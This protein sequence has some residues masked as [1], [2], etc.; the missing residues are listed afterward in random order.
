[1]TGPRSGRREIF[2][3]TMMRNPSSP[4]INQSEFV[5]E[6]PTFSRSDLRDCV[7]QIE[8]AIY[9]DRKLFVI[10]ARNS[11]LEIDILLVAYIALYR[12]SNAALR[13]E[14]W[15]HKKDVE[16]PTVRKLRRYRSHASFASGENL[17][18]IRFWDGVSNTST[19]LEKG[20]FRDDELEDA[21]AS[22]AP[23]LVITPET[24]ASLFSKPFR[25]TDVRDFV[26][27]GFTKNNEDLRR[28]YSKSWLAALRKDKHIGVRRTAGL[29]VP[30]FWRS[31]E[32]AKILNFYLYKGRPEFS[33][34]SYGGFAQR[35][36]AEYF[37]KLFGLF[38]EVES[39]P[40][41]YQFIFYL[42]LT[43]DLLPSKVSSRSL[44]TMQQRIRNLWDLTSRLAVGISELAGNIVQHSSEG[45]GV[46]TLRLYRQHQYPDLLNI[47]ELQG[48]SLPAPFAKASAVLDV[49]VVDLGRFGVSHTLADAIRESSQKEPNE[50]L[51]ASFAE[52]ER[53]LDE[54]GIELEDLLDPK[55]GIH[56]THQSKRAV[57]HLGLQILSKIMIDNSGSINASTWSSHG[58]TRDRASV[59]QSGNPYADLDLVMAGTN[60]NILL[61]VYPDK[62]YAVRLSG[63]LPSLGVATNA[64][65]LTLEGFFEIQPCDVDSPPPPPD[66]AEKRRR[67]TCFIHAVRPSNKAHREGEFEL[68][69]DL[70]KDC[71]N[72]FNNATYRALDFEGVS[73]ITASGLFRFLGRWELE[74]PGMSLILYNIRNDTL[75]DLIVINEEYTSR[76]NQPDPNKMGE[77]PFWSQR[78]MQLIYSYVS[79]DAR[80]RFHLVDALWGSTKDEFLSANEVV[81]NT[82][83]NSVTLIDKDDA[84]EHGRAAGRSNIS[85]DLRRFDVFNDGVNLLPFDLLLAGHDGGTLF[86]QNAQFLLTNE[87]KVD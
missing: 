3:R 87:L 70:M 39:R 71:R 36:F 77:M 29:S 75:M 58:A 73:D 43:S 34:C 41:I 78:N 50:L 46:I 74:F 19:I 32:A 68:W 42:M 67:R 23:I 54:G 81:R 84:D 48:R 44:L 60:F 18:S 51:R 15:L 80:H 17:F 8:S 1:M 62:E 82:N 52:D 57:A 69:N 2:P 66:P 4:T 9:D 45:K 76:V 25:E 13:F 86:E 65:M 14:I 40:P 56:L 61:P 30:A 64:E 5:I 35:D 28:R 33:E 16:G 72:S 24:I 85:H 63:K 38:V 11:L 10:K 31:L 22:F 47:G 79:K 7:N 12:I 59:F 49:N 20:R 55:R 21:G 83:Y 37:E 53:R 27:P 26:R 6:R